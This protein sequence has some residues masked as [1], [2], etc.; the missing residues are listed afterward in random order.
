MGKMG[1]RVE[2]G[3]LIFVVLLLCRVLCCVL[4]SVFV[5]LGAGCVG[6]VRALLMLIHLWEYYG[7]LV[8][9]IVLVG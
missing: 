3:F 8:L 6:M 7:C 9:E 4:Y 5:Y 2:L 1:R